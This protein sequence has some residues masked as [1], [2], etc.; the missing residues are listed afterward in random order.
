MKRLLVVLF[1]LMSV[2]VSAQIFN[3]VEWEFTQKQ[4][5]DTEIELLNW[6]E[7]EIKK[8]YDVNIDIK[9]LV[10]SK[11]SYFRTL[12]KYFRILLKWKAPSFIIE[13]VSYSITNQALNSVAKEFK[14][15][16]IELQHGVIDRYH[17]WYS[18]WNNKKQLLNYFPDYIFS[19][20]KYW[21]S[22]C[23]YPSNCKVLDLWFP[24]FN[25]N[26]ANEI[27]IEKKDTKNILVI[28]QWAIW[29]DLAKKIFD[30]AEKLNEYKF[31]YKLHPWE[32]HKLD[33]S[34]SYL[35]NVK[36]IEIVKWERTI[37]EL[38]SICN[39]QIWVFSTAVYEGL[40]FWLNSIVYNLPWVEYLDDLISTWVVKKVN[41]AEECI[42]L[43]NNWEF[44][45]SWFN[46]SDFFKENSLEL[47]LQEIKKL[48]INS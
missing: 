4:L 9:E 35:K 39:I 19:W 7:L 18:M 33:S 10:I 20:W 46:S 25:Y 28:S 17:L 41:T 30:L 36:N 48:S 3:P 26:K 32:F 12:T 2:V 16:L 27:N 42:N 13:V 21:N 14:I 37:Y 44:N 45:N 23:N 47:I 43:I 29:E 34:L 24:F 1:T 6:L 38:F 40:G 22:V 31:Y 8:I 5:S 11:L 15:K